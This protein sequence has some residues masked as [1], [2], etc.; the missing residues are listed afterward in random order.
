M[1]GLDKFALAHGREAID[2][3]LEKVSYMLEQGRYVPGLDHGVPPDVSWDNYRYFFDHLRELIWRYPPRPA[4]LQ[5]TSQ[6][7][8]SSKIERSRS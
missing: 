6:E 4:Q 2:K 3:E 8:G 7:Q 5:A 1:G